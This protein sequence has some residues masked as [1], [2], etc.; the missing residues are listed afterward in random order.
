M[1]HNDFTLGVAAG[2]VGGTTPTVGI[3]FP[4]SSDNSLNWRILTLNVGMVIL[5]GNH[6]SQYSTALLADAGVDPPYQ[7]GIFRFGL[8]AIPNP[9]TGNNLPS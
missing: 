9:S 5:P 4:L 6:P 2:L 3:S 8:G 7:I 1:K